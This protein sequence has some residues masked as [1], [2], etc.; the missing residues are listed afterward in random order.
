MHTSA[1]RL[2]SEE[3]TDEAGA[4]IVNHNRRML[5]SSLDAIGSR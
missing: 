4:T 3:G 2:K 1:A 5:G